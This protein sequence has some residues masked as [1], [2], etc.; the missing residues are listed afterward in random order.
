MEALVPAVPF[1]TA[2]PASPCLVRSVMT[3]PPY[4]PRN[5]DRWVTPG[6][7]VAAI[8][9]GGVL[10]LSVVAAMVYLTVAGLDPDPML[11]LSAQVGGGLAAMLNL[12]LSLATR[13]TAAKTERNTG[14]LLR[15]AE[16]DAPGRHA[17]PGTDGT[18]PAGPLGS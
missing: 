12:W 14:T 5:S 4:P 13:A 18:A 9:V 1:P 8:V 16:A 15:Q 3:P 7:V 2:G 17:A 6:V 10:V 11:K